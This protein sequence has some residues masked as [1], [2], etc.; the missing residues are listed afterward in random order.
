MV[1]VLTVRR[2]PYEIAIA[3][4]H[5][6]DSVLVAP[7]QGHQAATV[8]HDF[9]SG[10][11]EHL[12]R[13]GHFD[14]DRVGA[15][16]E[17]DDSALCDCRNDRCGGAACRCSVTDDDVRVGDTLGACSRRNR[18]VAVGIA[19]RGPGARWWRHRRQAQ[20]PGEKRGHL[21]TQDVAVGAVSVV[22]W[23]VASLGDTGSGE[24]VDCVFEDSG[25]VEEGSFGCGRQ[26]ESSVE[27]GGHLAP[28]YGSIRTEEVVEWWVASLGDTGSGEP[29]DCVLEDS[30]GVE[31][32]GFGCGRQVESSVEEGGHL[33]PGYGSIRTE[34]VVEW[35]V[36]SL[37]DTG[38]GYRFDRAL[39]RAVVIIQKRA[40]GRKLVGARTGR[41]E[42]DQLQRRMRQMRCVCGSSPSRG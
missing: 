32:G 34:E 25:G 26:V 22:E 39:V 10:V 24:P 20:S 19:G 14:G 29:V 12:G 21:F 33:A 31:E 23:W 6:E 16:I 41:S 18:S 4:V 38:S 9:G 1:L 35:W 37:G 3:C 8:D 15:A 11:V 13:L 30:G 27:E 28:G 40:A 2:G 7:A 36:A 17:C 5:V 42:E